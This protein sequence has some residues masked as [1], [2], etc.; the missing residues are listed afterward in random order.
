MEP[1]VISYASI[2]RFITPSNIDPWGGAMQEGDRFTSEQ[3]RDMQRR[4]IDPETVETLKVTRKATSRELWWPSGQPAPVF[5]F[6]CPVLM[7]RLDGRVKV[8]SPSGMAKL[9]YA[10]GSIKKPRFQKGGRR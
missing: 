8:I 4:G 1:K 5:I 2:P 10:D 3:V 7:R 6:E 9:V